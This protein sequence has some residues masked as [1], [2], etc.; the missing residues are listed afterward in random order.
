MTT[1]SPTAEAAGSDHPPARSGTPAAW[2]ALGLVA[3]LLAGWMFADQIACGVIRTGATAWAWKRGEKIR[4]GHLEFDS[5]KSLRA[6]D[7]EWSRGQ[8]EHRSTF[9]CEMAILTPAPIRE[10]IMPRPG[11]D[12]LWIR[13]LWL[14]KTRLLLDARG[15]KQE[16]AGGDAMKRRPFIMPP[17]LLPGSIYAGPVEAVFIGES[18]RLAIHDL[19]LDL[20]SRWGGR[21]AFRAA[22]ADL[23]AGHRVIPAGTAR[24]YWEPGS[25]RIGNLPLGE[26]LSLGE[27]SLR[28]LPGRLD[29]GLRGTVGKG[30]IRGDG[31]LGGKDQL[32]VTLVGEHL[33]IDA[34]AGLTPSTAKA[35]GTIDQAR[36]SFRGDPQKPM[37]ADGS[38]RLVG[39][40][41]RWEGRGWESLRLAASMTGRT[42]TLSE[43]ELRQ[44]ENELVAEG[45]SSLPG[46][47]HAILR[48]P[49]TANFR[50][51]LTDAG[52]LA[53]LFGPDAGLLGGSLYLDGSVRGADN[54]AE[55]YCNFSGLGTKFRRLMV[56]WVKGCLLFEGSSTRIP[57]AEAAVGADSMALSGWSIENSRP[58]P[59]QGE[60]E[61]SVK[62]LARRLSELGAPVSPSIGAGALTGSWKGGGDMN[63]HHGE[64]R[65]RFNEWISRWTKGGISGSAEGSYDPA[66]LKLGK[67]R[68]TQKDLTLA[69]ELTA[70][71]QRLDL[72]S[73]SVVKEGVK[74]PLATGEISLPLNGVDLWTGGDPV[75]T[76]AMDQPMTVKLISE[77]L[78]AEQLM[79][80]LGQKTTCT[81][82]IDGWITA[83]G[84]PG[85]P[86]LNGSVTAAG[87]SPDSGNVSGDLKL[88]LRTVSG[89][90]TVTLHQEQGTIGLDGEYST[91]IKLSKKEGNLV[92]DPAAKLNGF[93]RLR[94][95]PLDGW[96]SMLTDSSS[97]VVQGV[98]ADGETTFSGTVGQP[99]AQGRLV[100]QAASADLSRIHRLEDLTVPLVFSNT[101]AS[102]GEGS[103]RYRGKPVALSGTADWSAG[104][105]APKYSVR[106]S[107]TNL[108]IALAPDLQA[109]ATADLTYTRT[110]SSRAVLGGSLMLDP[111]PT[112]LARRMAPVFCPP[113]LCLGEKQPPS[114]TNSVMQWDLRLAT[115][116]N[117]PVLE[118]PNVSMSLHLTGRSDMPSVEGNVTL[119]G[120][121]IVLPGGSFNVPEAAITFTKQ[122]SSLSGKASG[123]TRAGLGSIQLGG[124]LEHPI[125]TIDAG[126]EVTAADWI[127]ACAMPSHASAA[128][129]LMATAWLRQQTVLPV[130]ARSWS[131]RLPA[132]ADLA[133]LGF[134]GT[135]WVWNFFPTASE[136]SG[137][138]TAR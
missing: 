84:T 14:A 82:K 80:L 98:T 94:K 36:L 17:A 111:I 30:L 125:A 64:F 114:P 11:H 27:L 43:L 59:Y 13:E 48:A 56:D 93:L 16:H 132:D 26:G 116:T 118:G 24:A 86:E 75:K 18:G 78:R 31:S 108:P 62:D 38:V 117:A 95:L 133:A 102:I 33:A 6:T 23:G 57:Y 65:I 121:T 113:G 79:N 77:G 55:G 47:W 71:S 134:Y 10:L 19:R 123:L 99:L 46:D 131:T 7:I 105:N 3:L 73:I 5:S 85:M 126:G 122:G 29:F 54:K 101:V 4:I 96:I 76:L 25:L 28:L 12:R 39:R 91:A 66:G 70:T 92:S 135:P 67:L 89:Q 63:A 50:A 42:L 112:D 87:Y 53:S 35:A 119:A 90:T 69:M 34:I 15:E 103:A 52:S 106:I 129:V 136:G 124:S 8:G 68:M 107:G 51:S 104:M 37:D 9:R 45:H 97:S 83:G 44:G 74:K 2:M 32:E 120:Q 137:E 127:F 138:Q 40:N 115:A 130:P 41:F 61:V 22:E 100:L 60:A 128:P 109:T 21:V 20:P 58:H 1:L 88:G 72:A 81:G 49:F 110:D